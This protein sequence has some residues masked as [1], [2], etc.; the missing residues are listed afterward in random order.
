MTK[1]AFVLS[2][3]ILLPISAAFAETSVRA[4]VG[5]KMMNTGIGAQSD[6]NQR[7]GVLSASS[8]VTARADEERSATG[9][10]ARGNN[11]SSRADATSSTTESDNGRGGMMSESHRSVMASFVQSLLADSERD[12]GIGAEVRAVAK[13]QEDSASTTVDAIAHMENRGSMM[14]FFLGTD[15]RNV[16]TLRSQIAK[17]TTDIGRLQAAIA[18][19][20]DTGVKTSLETQV[21][22]LTAEQAKVQA[23]VDAHANSFSLFGWFTRLFAGNA[24]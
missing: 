10:E 6:E 3:V 21:T 15:W 23:F 24:Q 8:S 16:G 11:E 14:S 5:V 20:T 19:T 22:A 9:T 17:D 1:L 2:F 7:D 18:S 12:G 4:D 13:S